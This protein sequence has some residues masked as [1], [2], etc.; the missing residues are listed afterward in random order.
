[1]RA[2]WVSV[3][4]SAMV[5]FPACKGSKS[6]TNDAVIVLD[7][8]V[9]AAPDAMPDAMPDAAVAPIFRNPVATPDLELAQ[10]ALDIIG[11]TGTRTTSCVNCHRSIDRQYLRYWRAMTDY[12]LKT[13][14]TDLSLST[15]EVAQKTINCFRSNEN[16]PD[17][18]FR[19]S[20]IGVVAAGAKSP[21]FEFAFWRG[22][23]DGTDSWKLKF[24]NWSSDVG[25]P[26]NGAWQVPQEEFDILAEWFARGLPEME[27]ILPPDTVGPSQCTAGIS[28]D[29]ASVLNTTR[30]TGWRQIH[31][32]NALSMLGCQNATNAQGCLADKAKA[33]DTAY[34]D[35]WDVAGL[36]QIRMLQI[37][38]YQTSYWSRSSADGRFFGH[39]GGTVASGSVVDLQTG[40]VIPV[41]AP[42]DPGFF[43]DN[44]AF[45]FQAAAGDGRARVCSQS[46]LINNPTRVTFQE[47]QCGATNAGLY[48]HVGKST[49]T[50]GDFFIVSGSWS[51][52]PSDGRQ[53]N[54]PRVIANGD[55]DLTFFPM[56]FDGTGY[57]EKP[58]TTIPTPFEG[59]TVIS[60]S[61]KLV[62]SRVKGDDGK[63]K[64]YVLRKVN[65]TVV[66]DGYSIQ[67]PEI[68]RY[69]EP[70][71][72]PAFSYDDRWIVFHHYI[73]DAD[74]ISLGF[75]GANDPAF[76]EY[77][78]KGASD[79][80]LLDL[81]TGVK[82]RISNMQ[83]GQYALFP[84]FR[85]DGWVYWLVK[86]RNRNKEEIVASP[87][88]LF[89][90]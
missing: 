4:L 28:S 56:I 30:T 42:Y 81:R 36:G 10:S 13:C 69:C 18:D 22:F 84:H 33:A 9:D 8:S 85:A 52:D 26:R 50:G 35:K 54:D 16:N 76:A 83:P 60:P 86:D 64:G 80:Y 38:N 49:E 15:T 7:A 73:G 21:W 3:V 58:T 57:T 74:A 24:E 75:T 89:L 43:P 6:V 39:G 65:S 17:A 5:V 27:T 12:A 11:I 77:R 61:A 47:P 66:G 25:M 78:A 82:T 20:H 48:Q 88:S 40:R 71:T 79:I 51:G 19:M 72:K 34:A 45:M 1:M 62:V 29:V 14:I 46:L 37:L 31:A 59:D 32:D 55:S 90:E 41:D 2:I 70:G 44:S 68:A 53:F 87:A 67:A 63:Q 23:N